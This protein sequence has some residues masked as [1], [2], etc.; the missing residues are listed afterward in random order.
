MSEREPTTALVERLREAYGDG[1]RAVA[2]YDREG[3]TVHYRDAAVTAAYDDPDLDAIYEDVVLG[4]VNR[5]FEETLFDDLGDV[6]GKLRLFADGTVAHFW[7][8]S[9]DAGVLVAF[10]GSVDVAVRTL[11]GIV[12]E[13]YG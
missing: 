4:D 11:H 5:G 2:T 12:G 1:L 3:Y 6:E 13:H 9:D 8:R 10:D 7:P